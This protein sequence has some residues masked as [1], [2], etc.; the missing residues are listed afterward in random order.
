M[1]LITDWKKSKVAEEDIICYK[2]YEDSWN[3]YTSPYEGSPIPKFNKITHVDYFQE[4]SNKNCYSNHCYYGFHSFKNRKDNR[5]IP[6]L[7]HS[8]RVFECV[9]PKGTK[10]YEGYI[11]CYIPKGNN[12]KLEYGTVLC[13]CSEALI[14]KPRKELSSFTL[15]KRKIRNIFIYLRLMIFK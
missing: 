1:C 9:I 5:V 4:T 7:I 14:V 8:T 6:S 3:G 13:Y 2:V 15:L 11:R 10:Y 12:P